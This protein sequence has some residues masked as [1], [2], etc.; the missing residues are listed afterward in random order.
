M[1]LTVTQGWSV[2]QPHLITSST[3]IGAR[4]TPSD[5]VTGSSDL[6]ASSFSQPKFVGES[7]GGSCSNA[8]FYT[9]TWKCARLTVC[10]NASIPRHPQKMVHDSLSSSPHAPDNC[11]WLI[12]CTTA[13][14]YFEYIHRCKSNAFGY[15]DWS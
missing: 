9:D 14:D 7:S 12:R 2:V 10:S 5:I 1:H 3:S 11:A 4:A 8:A 15:C 13:P 6:E